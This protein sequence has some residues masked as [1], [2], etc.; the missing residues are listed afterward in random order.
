MANKTKVS[1]WTIIIGVLLVVSLL[2]TGVFSTIGFDRYIMYDDFQFYDKD[3]WNF[4][5][6]Y[7]EPANVNKYLFEDANPVY[8]GQLYIKGDSIKHIDCDWK[9]SHHEYRCFTYYNIGEN[10]CGSSTY[11]DLR[12]GV[13]SYISYDELPGLDKD[14]SGLRDRNIYN[15]P[16]LYIVP[17][18][19][20]YKADLKVDMEAY[21]PGYHSSF[22]VV[23]NDV[24]VHEIRKNSQRELV[25]IKHSFL[26]P[27][28]V[29]VYVDGRKSHTVNTSNP[30]GD[31]RMKF[32]VS[33]GPNDHEV[34]MRW[35]IHSIKYKYIYN[36]QIDDDEVK[37]TD[38][39]APGSEIDIN[40]LSYE[41][42]Q[43]CLDFPLKARSFTEEG[44]RVD[45]RGETLQSLVRGKTLTVPENEEWYVTYIAKYQD[46]MTERCNIGEAYDTESQSCI[47][48][49]E[50]EMVQC[51]TD[52]D[53]KVPPGCEGVEAVCV[54][55][56]CQFNGTCIRAPTGETT[57]IWEGILDNAFFNWIAGFFT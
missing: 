14:F 56:E 51:T 6:R 13:A 39:F 44:V 1:G 21:S 5:N 7:G 16:P 4:E 24:R 42:A 34:N 33:G 8:Y 35:S 3:K 31:G 52:S 36:C 47:D 40:S 17:Q 27:E 48:P 26:H 57:N 19:N 15:E 41:P 25:E 38:T 12:L 30:D 18:K 49:R 32:M 29:T 53:C 45:D 43:F 46:G 23:I 2:F 10:D 55:G 22:A 54:S 50:T 28:I 11:C 20:L 9:K 37:V